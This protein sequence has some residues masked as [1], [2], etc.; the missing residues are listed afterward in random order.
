MGRAKRVSAPRPSTLPPNAYGASDSRTQPLEPILP[1]LSSVTAGCYVIDVDP[2]ACIPLCLVRAQISNAVATLKSQINGDSISPDYL[3]TGMVSASPTCVVVPLEGELHY[4]L[5]DF[6]HAACESEEDVSVRKGRF[7]TWYGVIDGCQLHGAISQLRTELPGKWGSFLWKVIAVHPTSSIEQY[8][9]LARVQNERTK[10]SYNYECTVH[11]LLR[12]LRLE[13]DALYEDQLK[14]SRLGARSVKVTRR[15]VAE[16]YDGGDHASNTTIKQAV[17]LASRLSWKTIEVLGEIINLDCSDV[18]S[19]SPELNIHSLSSRQAL[20]S[21]QDCRLFKR[22]VTFGALRGAQAF[23]SAVANGYEQAQINSLYRIKH[24]SELHDYKSVNSKTISEQFQLSIL[25]LKEEDKFLSA[26]GEDDWPRNMDTAKENLLCSTVCDK[27]IQ[28]NCGNDDDVL[29]SLWVCFKRLFPGKARALEEQNDTSSPTDQAGRDEADRT[30][31]PPEDAPSDDAD[32]EERERERL[33]REL[34]E[35]EQK[36][37]LENERLMSLHTRADQILQE[38]GITCTNMSFTNFS[39][40][41]WSANSTRSD[42]VLSSLPS[43]C[44]ED[45]ITA[46]PQFC[47]NVLHSGSYCFL[48]LS[49]AQ[50]ATASRLF[51]ENNFK[52]F[53]HSFKILYDH[54][55]I[56]RRATT[57][58]P[59]KYGDIAFIAKTNGNHPSKFKPSFDEDAKRFASVRNVKM[60]PD[61]LK[62]PST[63]NALVPSEKNAALYS[64]IIKMFS[65]TSGNVLDPLAGPLTTAIACLQTGRKCTCLEPNVEVFRYAL[66]RVRVHAVPEATMV[67]HE[68]YSAKLTASDATSQ[69]ARTRDDDIDPILSSKR[70]RLSSATNNTSQSDRDATLEAN[71]ADENREPRLS[72]TG[73]EVEREVQDDNISG[74]NAQ[75]DPDAV[76]ALLMIRST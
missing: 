47:K 60:C 21:Q 31:L 62:K 15:A 30:P 73:D 63:N 48:I 52:V 68:D 71:M 4:L 46:M 43:D 17:T 76:Q 27:E 7:P 9:Q 69:L 65:P 28:A 42:L 75:P 55:T 2:D 74:R 12:G 23:M 67:E 24:W 37:R 14:K 41:V 20:F 61:R 45:I 36:N 3:L 16:R 1:F 53:Q 13:Y 35:L 44:D 64:H 33:Q 59:Q 22:C 70:R 19:S 38:I 18:I 49:E 8:R 34:N 25:A 72:P 56:P 32:L 51:L 57:D 50:F 40:H 29:T 5:D 6:L 58:F 10:S 26:I 54:K 39:K 11:D 66:G